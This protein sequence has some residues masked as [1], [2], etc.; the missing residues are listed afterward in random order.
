MMEDEQTL[1]FHK[2]DSEPTLAVGVTL[3]GSKGSLQSVRKTF[4]PLGFFPSAR[5]ADKCG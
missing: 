5:S 1:L 3:G 2:P 4:S